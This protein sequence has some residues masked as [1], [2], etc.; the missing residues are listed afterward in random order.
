VSGATDFY[1]YGLSGERQGIYSVNVV[2]GAGNIRFFR[3][4][5]E[6]VIPKGMQADSH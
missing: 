1:L 4:T 5:A 6:S 3:V 2:D